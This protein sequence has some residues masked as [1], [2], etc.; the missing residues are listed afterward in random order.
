MSSFK[1]YSFQPCE[2]KKPKPTNNQ[3]KVNDGTGIKPIKDTTKHALAR[4]RWGNKWYEQDKKERMKAQADFRAKN[5]KEAVFGGN[6]GETKEEEPSV[7]VL[8]GA[9]EQMVQNYDTGKMEFAE[10]P[11]DAFDL[12]FCTIAEYNSMFGVRNF[13]YRQRYEQ[14]KKAAKEKGQ[15]AVNA[16]ILKNNA[17]QRS[18]EKARNEFC[19]KVSNHSARITL[20]SYSGIHN[21][22]W[23]H[24]IHH[25][26][27]QEDL[28]LAYEKIRQMVI[29]YG[30]V[31][32]VDS[33]IW[34]KQTS[35]RRA[36]FLKL[37]AEDGVHTLIIVSYK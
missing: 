1:Q 30:E 26:A 37:L 17:L 13:A 4:A 10:A 36:N 9:L 27:H 3:F 34:E 21:Y 15:A 33:E 31:F 18:A 8:R 32:A 35:E 29:D 6:E 7:R 11:G 16:V 22:N 20:S 25:H 19:K 2:P 24:Y 28:F 5:D 14:E 12:V 23:P